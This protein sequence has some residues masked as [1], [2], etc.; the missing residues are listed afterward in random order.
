MAT[1]FHLTIPKLGTS[2]SDIAV[3]AFSYGN[4]DDLTVTV[5]DSGKGAALANDSGDSFGTIHIT[6]TSTDGLTTTL[7]FTDAKVIEVAQSPKTVTLTLIYSSVKTTIGCFAAGT[8]I[9]TPR[10]PVAIE[11]LAVGEPVLTASGAAAPI[12]WL[13]HRRV[14]C[15][16]HPDPAA[17][18][19]V[20]IRAGAFADG[21]PQR[22]LLLSPDHAVQIDGVL[23]PV[24]RLVNAVSIAVLPMAEVTYWHLELPQHDVVLAEG[25]P[26]ETY[27]GADPRHGFA[28]DGAAMALHPDFAAGAVLPAAPDAALVEPI[29]RRLAARAGVAAP[30]SADLAPA[31]QLLAK[32]E[33]LRPVF[34]EDGAWM[35]VPPAGALSLHLVSASGRPADASPWLD[36]RRRLGVCVSRIAVLGAAGWRD[37]PLDHPSFAQGW[38]DCERRGDL[39]SRWTDGAAV[40]PLDGTAQAV[41]LQVVAGTPPAAHT[42]APQ[43]AADHAEAVLA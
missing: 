1:E 17:V 20:C 14:T 34:A 21:L 16:R 24:R 39:L 43:A 41:R 36:D 12:R 35:F 13:G 19:P 25:L 2:G 30:V 15:A 28:T 27:R 7:T 32:G 31:L 37:L 4:G 8:R 23:I 10:G 33:P 11:A 26:A 22:D 18:Y 40:I 6:E 9:L 3:T 42:A 29:W 38:W 5:H